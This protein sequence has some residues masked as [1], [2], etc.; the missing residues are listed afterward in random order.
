[1]SSG[2]RTLWLTWLLLYI[3]SFHGPHLS[4]NSIANAAQATAVPNQLKG[5][6]KKY[7]VSRFSLADSIRAAVN[8]LQI[9]AAVVIVCAQTGLACRHNCRGLWG[10]Q[11]GDQRKSNDKLP[12]RMR[13]A[14]IFFTPLEP[15]CIST[16]LKPSGH[17]SQQTKQHP[18][19]ISHHW[20]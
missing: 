10:L 6:P 9:M 15:L 16:S 8:P 5:Q 19:A 3:G 14:C 11:Y 4:C 2:Q 1:M 17:G 18:Y 12:V 13:T 20:F 7:L